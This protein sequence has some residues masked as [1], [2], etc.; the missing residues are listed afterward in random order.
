MTAAMLIA[1]REL[2]DRS[3]LFLIAAAMAVVPF[4][5]ALAVRE[6]RSLAIATVAAFLATA[7]SASL[8]IALGVSAV[9]REMTEKRLSFFFAKPVSPASI[10]IGKVTAGLAT[11]FGALVLILLPTYLFAHSGWSSMWTTGGDGVLAYA[12][13]SGV[14]FFFFGHTASTMLRSRSAR[15]GIDFALMVVMALTMFAMLRPILMGGGLDIVMLILAVF[16]GAFLLLLAVAPIWQLSRGRVDARGNHAALSTAIWSGAAVLVLIAAGYAY[17]VISPPLSQIADIFAIEQSPSGRWVYISGQT[18]GRGSYLASFLVDTT[19]GERER[20]PL[21]AWGRIHYS[22]D[23]KLVAWL[24]PAELL[25]SSGMFRLHTRRLEPNAKLVA[26]PLIGTMPRAAALSEDGS[27]IAL[28]RWKQLAVYEVATGRLLGAANGIDGGDVLTMMFG[29]PDIVRVVDRTAKVMHVREFDLAH[30]KLTTTIERTLPSG[31]IGLRMTADGSRL[32]LRHDRAI[33]DT[34]SGATVAV[35]P[36]AP[37]KPYFSTMLRDGSS[38]VTRDSKLYHFD[39]SGKLVGE[40]PI[41]VRQAGVVGQLGTSKVLLAVTRNDTKDWR[42]LVVDLAS[43]TLERTINN[44]AGPMP[45]WAEPVLRQFPE[46]ATFVGMD[47]S[48]HLLL[49]DPRTGAKRAFPT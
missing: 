5:A 33:V 39:P 44:V 34:H 35:L 32:Y 11:V 10:W 15:V 1:T 38:I 13:I 12:V 40:V 4:F 27:R 26:T 25:P 30:R 14:V 18:P 36:L 41:P 19:N 8:A 3:R 23:G 17:W 16:S 29:T 22:G 24:E 20:V 46:D 42:M 6:N 37:E 48:R 7:Y 21:S 43:H 47:T 2:R 49:W 45:T 9:G 31:Y 28:V